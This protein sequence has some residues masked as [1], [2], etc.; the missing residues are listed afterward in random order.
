VLRSSVC[1]CV[2]VFVVPLSTSVSCDTNVIQ[3]VVDDHCMVA[4]GDG[5]HSVDA[6]RVQLTTDINGNG[7]DLCDIHSVPATSA[8]VPV[9]VRII[10]AYS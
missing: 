6:A 1:L 8:P 9:S 10:Q 5:S 4:D 2:R 3:S 7:P